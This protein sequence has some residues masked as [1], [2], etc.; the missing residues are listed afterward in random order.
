[1]K[2]ITF[3]LGGLIA[4]IGVANAQH[5]QLPAA[6]SNPVSVLEQDMS[7]QPTDASVAVN[8]NGTIPYTATYGN[9]G[10][11]ADPLIVSTGPYF[12]VAGTG[13]GPDKSYLEDASLGM[14][15]YGAGAQIASGNSVADDF[16]LTATYNI[17]S[18]D[19]YSYQTGSTPPSITGVY[20]QVWDG[21]PSGGGS[22]VWGDMD[23][24]ILIGAESA[25]A[26]R[27]LESGN[28]SSMDRQIQRVTA[29]T[30]G[31]TLD[32][33]T[34]WV[35]YSFEG[36]GSSGPWAPPVVILG[37]ATTGNAMQNL[38]QTTG[39]QALLDGGTN[40]PQGVPVD[41]YGTE[42]VSVADNALAGFSFFPNPTSDVLNLGAQKNIESVSLFNLLG[43]KVMTVKVDATTSS[44]NLGSLATGTYVMQVTVQGQTGTYKVTKK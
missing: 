26:L 24:N 37:E 10:N 4:S 2:K 32:P 31:L 12:N 41:I 30:D 34:Y 36:S 3:L 13:G 25:N 27:V 39:W 33:G 21:D 19:V 17:T 29:D 42:V 40:T 14:G 8:L 43:Q 6:Y 7:I 28:T 9:R 1:M 11:N 15:T 20:M 38:S 16:V 23:T 35:E 18:I 44:I 22:I 5:V